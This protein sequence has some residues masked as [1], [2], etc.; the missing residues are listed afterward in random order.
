MATKKKGTLT[1]SGEW[2]KHLRKW[3][4]RKFWKAE[5][6]EEGVQVKAELR[7]YNLKK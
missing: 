2:A 7:D 1:T 4:K 3:F 6:A 5:R